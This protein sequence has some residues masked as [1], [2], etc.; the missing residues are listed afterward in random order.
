M[1]EREGLPRF[2]AMRAPGQAHTFHFEPGQIQL[3]NNRLLGHR[4]TAFQ[5]WPEAERK[6]LLVRLWLRGWGRP[7]YNG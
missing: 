4:R 1:R 6:R 7:F 2:D 3:V 5:D